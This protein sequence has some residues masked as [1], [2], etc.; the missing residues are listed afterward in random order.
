MESPRNPFM[1]EGMA[2]LAKL[3]DI[4]KRWVIIMKVILKVILIV[5][6]KVILIVIAKTILTKI[7]ILVEENK[8]ENDDD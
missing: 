8:D 5:I 2:Q 6:L 3:R 1:C 7:L 4:E